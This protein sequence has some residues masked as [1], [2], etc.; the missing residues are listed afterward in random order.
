MTEKNDAQPEISDEPN[1]D[2]FSLI[3]DEDKARIH[4]FYKLLDK[5]DKEEKQNDRPG[6]D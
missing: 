4:A 1:S 3:T 2:D 5:W 6:Q